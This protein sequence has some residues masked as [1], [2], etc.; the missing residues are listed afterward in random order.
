MQ[1]IH[2]RLKIVQAIAPV[3]QVN[4]SAAIVG[5]IIDTAGFDSV[6]FAIVTGAL[7]DANATLRRRWST[8]MIPPSPTRRR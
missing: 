1:D 6:E 5:N 8:A 2:N 4:S 3:V 7:T